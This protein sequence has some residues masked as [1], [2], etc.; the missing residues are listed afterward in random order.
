[1][2]VPALQQSIMSAGYHSIVGQKLLHVDWNMYD[3]EI[4]C[5]HCRNGVLQND[6]TNFSK[7]KLLFPMFV[8]DGPPMWAMVMSM[9][10][11]CCRH[12]VNANASE[13]LC[14]LPAYA[15]AGYPV[16][17]KYALNKNS[18]LGVSAT[19]VFDLLI[20]TYGNGDL[21]SRL[22][23]HA[24]NKSYLERVEDYYSFYRVQK[25]KE[26]PPKYVENH[27]YYIRAYPPTGDGIRDAYDSACSSS[28]TPWGISD[29][30]RHIREIQ[31]VGCKSIFAQDHTHKVTDNYYQK[32]GLG[33]FALWD[34]ANENGEIASAVLVP[35]TKTIHFSH[36][37]RA[38]TRRVDFK[39]LAMCSDAWPA[40][41]DFWDLTFRGLQG[42]LGLFHYI[43]R[44]T[45]TL[46]KNHIDHFRSVNGL[47]NC[48]YHY[49]DDDHENLLKALK[50]G[51]LSTKCTDDEISELKSTKT[52]KQRYDRHLR[53]EMRPAN[54][55]CSMLDD[56][57]VQFKCTSSDTSRPAR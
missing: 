2:T 5:P 7:N 53:K 31:R 44:I 56:W 42:R 3:L 22:L 24:I 48:I 8:I 30:D 40:K 27:G 50:E 39:P 35:S 15:R 45:R 29:H 49:N 32:K 33:A 55:M 46:K 37:A 20:P 19:T 10:C 51:T 43:Q 1:M 28:H 26:A 52:F 12:R 25:Q 6:R 38:L 4:K 11:P 9:T 41:S 36:A 34:C 21:C 17:S 14:N 16:E 57:F 18:H 54:I 13:I 23:H 47:L